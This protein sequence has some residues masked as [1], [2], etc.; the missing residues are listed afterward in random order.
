MLIEAIFTS[1][2]R[3][4]FKDGFEDWDTLQNELFSITICETKLH[5]RPHRRHTINPFA[6]TCRIQTIQKF[7]YP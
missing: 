1:D 2:V 5:T 4:F 7:M 6:F 3:D